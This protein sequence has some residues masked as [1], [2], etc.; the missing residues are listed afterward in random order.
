MKTNAELMS[1]LKAEL[2]KLKPLVAGGDE[3]AHIKF[4]MGES[5]YEYLAAGHCLTALDWF[6]GTS[7]YTGKSYLPKAA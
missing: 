5:L 7:Y 3:D 4:A 2:D 1:A 6:K